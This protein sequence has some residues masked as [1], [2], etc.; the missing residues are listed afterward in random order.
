MAKPTEREIIGASAGG[1]I[2]ALRHLSVIIVVLLCGLIHREAATTPWA[3]DRRLAGEPAWYQVGAPLWHAA[4]PGSASLAERLIEFVDPLTSAS[5][6]GDT[7]A[8]AS[9]LAAATAG[10]LLLALRHMGVPLAISLCLALGTVTTQLPVIGAAS[11]THALLALFAAASLL[12]ADDGRSFSWPR[13]FLLA[14]ITALG[15]MAHPLFL[16][17]AAAMWVTSALDARPQWR[18]RVVLGSIVALSAAA[19]AASAVM[20]ASLA[21]PTEDA[22]RPGMLDLGL[23]LLTGRFTADLQPTSTASFNEVAALVLPAPALL[24]LA[25]LVLAALYGRWSV[26]R[27]SVLP[28]AFVWFSA[29]TTWL[30]DV[31]AGAAPARIAALVLLASGFA[32]VW[33]LGTR[34]TRA[35][36]LSAAGIVAVAGIARTDVYSEA[37]GAQMQAFVDAA[38]EPDT[39]AVWSADRT[40]TARALLL[41]HSGDVHQRR[42]SNVVH[43]IPLT[44][45]TQAVVAFVDE[46]VR[47]P[48]EPGV[49][50]ATRAITHRSA[51][52]F[53][54]SQPDTRWL[55]LAVRG[56]VEGDFC[57]ELVSLVG[58][59]VSKP[60]LTGIAVPP[61]DGRVVAAS[62]T[63]T[64]DVPF[65]EP[66]PGST[67]VAPAHFQ[68]ESRTAARVTINGTVAA[69]SATGSAIAIF[70]RLRNREYGWTLGACHESGLPTIEDRRLR[71]AWVVERRE[72]ET[73]PA[74]PVITS[75]AVAV[76]FGEDGA[77]W[78]GAG[79]HGVE[80]EPMRWTAAHDATVYVV[81]ARA[82]TL[83]INL[84]AHIP[85]QTSANPLTLLWNGVPLASNGTFTGEGEWVVPG[86]LVRRGLNTL[87]LHVEELV[88][89]AAG[90]SDTRQL[91]AAVRHLSF[92]PIPDATALSSSTAPR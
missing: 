15:A 42:R 56:G 20:H 31:A 49:W 24:C 81:S 85:A 32:A 76:R 50:L 18:S 72:G 79:W 78:F 26:V 91:G 84:Q 16:A 25:A 17:F 29:A 61:L 57:R 9:V 62:G 35:L 34:G 54:A 11:V 60:A 65:G 47:Q 69:E 53:L 40:A 90:A 63:E 67:F 86:A 59:D 10:V 4:V 6:I 45:A 74:V 13:I 88:S 75:R 3:D 68:L 22:V 23:A 5:R 70:D 14:T 12:V 82:R 41:H 64:M 37:A 66:I 21:A 30:P 7:R 51:R 77:G 33:N 52:E 8:I 89:P 38:F 48:A 27:K 80:A 83:R 1:L 43:A 92:T 44:P 28:L 55:A 2:T 36:A 73:I 87:T 46:T 71:T 39:V 58:L 19:V